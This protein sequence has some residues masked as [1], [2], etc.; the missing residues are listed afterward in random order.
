MKGMFLLRFLTGISALCLGGRLCSQDL[1]VEN[2]V[3]KDRGET[4]EIT[5]DL[6][7]DAEKN[8][9]V[10]IRLSYNRGAT[11]PFELRGVEGDAGRNVKPGDGKKVM[12]TVKENF[13]EGLRGEN[14]VFAVTAQLQK[15]P[16][17]WP[18]YVATVGVVGGLVYMGTRKHVRPPPT[19]GVFTISIP[20]EVFGQ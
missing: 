9:E 5:Y 19:T 18:Y 10:T 1:K 6:E 16:V 15:N 3:F 12:W 20:V 13:P 11:F 7:G 8:Y 14:F 2:V 4:V 17:R